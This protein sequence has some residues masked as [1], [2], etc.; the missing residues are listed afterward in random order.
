MGTY[1]KKNQTITY[2]TKVIDGLIAFSDR[3]VI[4]NIILNLLSNASKYSS[5]GKEISLNLYELNKGIKIDI[6]DFGIG[7][8]KEE[9]VQLFGRFFRARNVINIEG[10]GLG[11]NIVKKYLSLV[12]GTISFKS[13]E[14]IGTTFSIIIPNILT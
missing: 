6:I 10:T 11:L 3:N 14:H 12:N 5:E 9:Q 8:P 2:H 1:L 13:K 4:K 7:I